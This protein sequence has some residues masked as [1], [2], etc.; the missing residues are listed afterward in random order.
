M[1]IIILF[2]FDEKRLNVVFGPLIYFR[3]QVRVARVMRM[4]TAG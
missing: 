4:M 1:K 2:H 3:I